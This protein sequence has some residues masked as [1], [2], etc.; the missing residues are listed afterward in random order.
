MICSM[1]GAILGALLW[2][3]ITELRG[4]PSMKLGALLAQLLTLIAAF[5]IYTEATKWGG[6]KIGGHF[7]GLFASLVLLAA[8]FAVIFAC[9]A[10][11]RYRKR[12]TE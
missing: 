7:G 2:N 10:W 4:Q 9:A 1:L 6:E 11:S 3:K 8:T 5:F 12:L